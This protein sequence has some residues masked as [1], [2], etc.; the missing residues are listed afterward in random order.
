MGGSAKGSSKEG[1]GKRGRWEGTHDAWGEGFTSKL[2]EALCDSGLSHGG[3]G[4]EGKRME[5]GRRCMS[6]LWAV[7]RQ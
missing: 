7:K 5:G 1:R 4:Q 2:S 3:S 6:S